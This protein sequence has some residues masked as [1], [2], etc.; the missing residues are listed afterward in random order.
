MDLA[1]RY[2]LPIRTLKNE[3]TNPVSVCEWNAGENSNPKT[4]SSFS[5]A[6]TPVSL[7]FLSFPFPCACAVK[8]VAVA[9]W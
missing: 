5:S 9:L 7:P 2:P 3:R 1:Q 4:W 8:N 6:H